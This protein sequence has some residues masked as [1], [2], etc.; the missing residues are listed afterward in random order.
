M[1]DVYLGIDFGTK[2][3]G[4]ALGNSM[5]GMARPLTVLPNNGGFF[6]TMNKLI[7]EWQVSHLILGLP[8]TMDGEEQEVTRQ[9]KKFA[10]KLTNQCQL[11]VAFVDERLSSFEAERQFKTLRQNNQAKAKNKEQ[12]DAMAAQ[13]ILQSFLDQ[14]KL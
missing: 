12:I 10:K 5:T 8:L 11:P 1:P 14:K 7:K 2:R 4:L 6:E 3:I 9:V 13:I